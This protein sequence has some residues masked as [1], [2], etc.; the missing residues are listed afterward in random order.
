MAAAEQ[1]AKSVGRQLASQAKAVEELQK[2][3]RAAAVAGS[4]LH[5]LMEKQLDELD[6]LQEFA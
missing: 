1:K 2:Q 5:L 6:E 3:L 4:D